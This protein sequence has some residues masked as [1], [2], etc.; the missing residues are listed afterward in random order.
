[1]EQRLRGVALEGDAVLLLIGAPLTVFL[2]AVAVSR[3][4]ALPLGGLLALLLFGGLVAAFV[5]V[6][7]Y[8]VAALM[9]LYAFLPAFKTFVAPNAGPIKDVVAIAA[10]AA[11]VLLT[12]ERQRVRATSP[13]DTLVALCIVTLMV[14]YIVNLGGGFQRESYDTAYFHGVRLVIEPLLL[15]LV[16]LS[17]ERPTLVFR[18]A[19][20]SLVATSVVVALYG[21][22]QQVIGPSGL[23]ALG[24]AWDVQIQLI[25]DQLRS[26]STLDDPFL[27]VAFLLIGLCAV[28][29]WMQRGAAALFAGTIITLGIA[30]GLVRT[31]ALVIVALLGIWLVTQKHP[32]PAAFALAAAILGSAVVFF[33]SSGG[34]ESQTVQSGNT[35][36]TLNGRTDE[37]RVA[38]GGPIDW[39]FGLGV[40]EVGTAAERA[41]YDLSRTLEE[42]QKSRVAS[43]DSGYFAAIADVGFV[44]LGVLLLLLGRLF[45]LA[46]RAA[47]LG[48]ASGRF[49]MGALLVLFLDATTRS[50]FTGFPT[51]FMC[52]LLVGVALASAAAEEA[53]VGNS[54]AARPAA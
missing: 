40:G 4:P 14:L 53:E 32:V 1:M 18:W 42:A 29:F 28:L 38:L 15:L 35:Y 50:S 24:Y 48:F 31:S 16:G 51:A 13:V 6:P 47:A 37:W 30:A 34:T 25:G 27:Y 11:V 39:P 43:V 9:P 36:L 19:M 26:F 54:P 8:A 45:M 3:G 49:A 5:A 17:V 20:S 7:H 41:T 46:R 10:I 44:G 33:G 23:V 21:L 2:A 52:L 22:V 12:I